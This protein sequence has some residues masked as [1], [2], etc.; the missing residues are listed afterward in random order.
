MRCSNPTDTQYLAALRWRSLD[1]VL[2]C[3]VSSYQFTGLWMSWLLPHCLL[4]VVHII[5]F[6]WLS[7]LSLLFWLDQGYSHRLSIDEIW[8]LRRVTANNKHTLKHFLQHNISHTSCTYGNISELGAGCLLAYLY[9]YLTGHIRWH[10]C[11][12]H[13][14]PSI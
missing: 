1:S 12:I 5:S 11:W 2:D 4:A 8:I 13:E 14:Q 3:Q 9:L 7:N 6:C 10:R